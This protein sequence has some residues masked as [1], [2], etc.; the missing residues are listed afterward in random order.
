[1]RAQERAP[2]TCINASIESIS[3]PASQQ[4]F[5]ISRISQYPRQ[6]RTKLGPEPGSV[7]RVTH[8]ALRTRYQTRVPSHPRGLLAKQ[9]GVQVRI[10]RYRGYDSCARCGYPLVSMTFQSA[11]VFSEARAFIPRHYFTLREHIVFRLYRFA[12]RASQLDPLF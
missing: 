3:S 11:S 9:A 5:S 4:S 10:V 8:F 12:R 7:A 2:I 1:M 6:S